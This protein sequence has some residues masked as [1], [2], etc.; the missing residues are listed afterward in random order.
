MFLVVLLVASSFVV[1]T[2]A[3][4]ARFRGAS[5]SWAPTANSGEVV[6]H[7]TYAA[8]LS[9]SCTRVSVGATIGTCDFFS[10]NAATNLLFA[11][12]LSVTVTALNA[13]ED[14][15]VGTNDFV[16]SYPTF[17]LPGAGPFMAGIFSSHPL[18][19]GGVR[20]SNLVNRAGSPYVVQTQVT[21]LGGNRS[22]VATFAP[23]VYVPESTHSTF[24]VPAKDPDGDR[25]RW[26]LSTDAEA[27][28]G[29]SPPNLMINP[30]NGVVTWN[31]LGLGY[32][33][34]TA[35]VIIEDLETSGN[36]KTQCPVDFILR[37]VPN[38]V[39]AAQVTPTNFFTVS[40]G[41][42]LS[43]QAL[44]VNTDSGDNVTL[45]VSG[46]P[47][48]ASL[49]PA[50]P[51]T[52]PTSVTSTF[53]W[54]PQ[55]SDLG[56]H[57]V[58]FT[59]TDS[60]G[61]Q[62]T[63]NVTVEVI[64]DFNQHTFVTLPAP[65]QVESASPYGTPVPVTALVTNDLGAPL[66]V[67]WTVDGTVARTD[68]VAG[69]LPTTSAALTFTGNYGLGPHTVVV[70]ASD[71][72]TPPATNTTFV[73][74]V[75]TTPPVI[76]GC[77]SALT[78][79]LVSGSVVIPDWRSSVQ[80]TDNATATADLKISQTPPPGTVV[81]KAGPHPVTFTVTDAS[82]NSSRC[83]AT[84]AVVDN[85]APQVFA[86]VQVLSLWPPNHDLQC[87][88]F[89][90]VVNK[91]DAVVTIQVFSNEPDVPGSGGNALG[92]DDR[93]SPDATALE[94]GDVVLRA[95]RVGD[96]PGRV[97]L[98]VA[99]AIDSQKN[100]AV[101]CKTVVVPKKPNATDVAAISAMADAAEA[102]F[103]AHGA[104]PAGYSQVGVGPVL[105]PKQTFAPCPVPPE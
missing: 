19:G 97:Y 80:A 55:F 23:V 99:T 18:N 100:L 83:Q 4:D 3:Q 68:A 65:V 33:N 2:S 72:A 53:F 46:L 32:T 67:N 95:E 31:N 66:S 40:L 104:P 14:W 54:A 79:Q 73:T 38:T 61:L 52:N 101:A 59:A 70:T 63:T 50:L 7:I 43:F 84:L 34:F 26:R 81:N 103:Q 42:S 6:F 89:S 28:G 57:T 77:P 13:A 48:G 5:I 102:W 91:A 86:S 8:R 62:S 51:L 9:T 21:A 39:P 15:F 74:V 27:G 35:Q 56:S 71:G 92:G 76:V 41:S 58:T 25:I 24:V 90:Y 36:P 22:P 30:T 49:T 12:R 82:G 10:L 75:D 1:R 98:I 20:V 64:K 105:G 94:N 60:T 69:S 29:S 87:V 47:A 11:N 96:G 78:L 17:G 45:T 93:F 85:S 88:G 16:F 44:G 37:V